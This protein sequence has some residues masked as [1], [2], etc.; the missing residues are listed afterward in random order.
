MVEPFPHRCLQG[1]QMLKEI[2]VLWLRKGFLPSTPLH[3]S[4]QKNQL[5]SLTQTHSRGNLSASILLHPSTHSFGKGLLPFAH[6]QETTPL[7][8]LTLA[9]SLSIHSLAS[10]H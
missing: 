10:D 4:T 5:S 2:L 6:V 7:I 9:N 3:R 1:N 8:S